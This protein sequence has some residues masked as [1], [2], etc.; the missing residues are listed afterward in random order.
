[1]SVS[2]REYKSKRSGHQIWGY[3]FQF[4]GHR[5][6]KA[7]YKTREA[8]S[9]AEQQKRQ[10]IIGNPDRAKPA[11]RV[12]LEE[13]TKECLQR[14]A[15]TDLAE[16]TLDGERRKSAALMKKLGRIYADELT[17]GDIEDYMGTRKAEGNQKRTIN[18][19]LTYLRALLDYAV[20]HGAASDNPARRIKLLRLDKKKR[21]GYSPEDL[22][23]FIEE[24]MKTRWGVEATTW[25]IV[26]AASG[27]RPLESFF[28]EWKNVQWAKNL[29]QVRSKPGCV[30]KNLLERD[31]PMSDTLR[32]VLLEWRKTWLAKFEGSKPPHDWIFFCPRYPAERAKGFRPSFNTARKRAGLPHLTPYD[33]RHYHI[34]QAIMGGAG[35]QAIAKW[36]GTSV[37]VIDQVYAHLNEGYLASEM[38]K[39]KVLDDP[40]GEV[41]PTG[42][43]EAHAKTSATPR[44][45]PRKSDSPI[46]ADDD[47][48]PVERVFEGEADH[49]R[50]PHGGQKRRI[51]QR[52][53]GFGKRHP[54]MRL[55][56][57]LGK[58]SMSHS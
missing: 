56:E 53:D 44:K 18:L 27:L 58:S 49:D 46:P 12:A 40:S 57:V 39:V 19:E 25:V 26:R 35:T 50:S 32:A 5:Y 3:D 36:C 10:F 17:V 8:A 48:R 30:L 16:T 2:K 24:L 22:Q 28:L 13:L 42:N 52:N 33:V 38:A 41:Q 11:R 21:P 7:G 6:R 29:I 9:I 1:M 43:G 20:E 14:R 34:S 54:G 4:R 55:M 31:V 37:G 23:R 45:S 51:L 15:G 47:A